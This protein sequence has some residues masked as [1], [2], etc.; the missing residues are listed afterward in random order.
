MNIAFLRHGLDRNCTLHDKPLDDL[1]PG[2]DTRLNEETV[3]PIPVQ[4]RLHE[5]EIEAEAAVALNEIDDLLGPLPDAV[6]DDQEQKLTASQM[7]RD[8]VDELGFN[9]VGMA[10]GDQLIQDVGALPAESQGNLTLQILI[11]P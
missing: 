1:G 9:D 3:S 5:G 11:T 2:H 7:A 8:V 10:F 4:R 6:A